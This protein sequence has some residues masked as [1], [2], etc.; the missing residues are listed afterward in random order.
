MPVLA[1]VFR[2]VLNG[3]DFVLVRLVEVV[4]VLV[5]VP[6]GVVSVTVTSHEG[7]PEED[8]KQNRC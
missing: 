7:Q 4:R 3:S 8:R 1:V 2:V 5:I 6:D